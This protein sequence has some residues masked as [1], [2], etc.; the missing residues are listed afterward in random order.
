MIDRRIVVFDVDDTL[1]QTEAMIRVEN[2]ETGRVY[3][4][5]PEEFN[6][7]TQEPQERLQFDEFSCPDIL[8]RGQ[9]IDRYVY[10]LREAHRR[11]IRT[12]ILTAR[13]NVELIQNWLRKRVNVDIERRN[14][15][16]ISN[17]MN[18]SGSIQDRKQQ[19]VEDIYL[20]GYR[21]IKVIDDDINNLNAVR[22]I[23]DVYNDVYVSTRLAKKPIRITQKEKETQ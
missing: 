20:R 9:L 6:E 19:A 7:Y 14:I 17:N 3:K 15:Y 21:Y 4:L 11:N 5:T 10:M 23:E 2:T 13:D 12:A 18:Y 1:V 22:R 16:C 8:N